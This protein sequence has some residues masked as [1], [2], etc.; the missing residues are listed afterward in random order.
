MTTAIMAKRI[1]PMLATDNHGADHSLLSERAGIHADLTEFE[2][3]HLSSVMVK[4]FVF[5]RQ[6]M[7][8]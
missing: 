5:R 7:K 6:L 4:P 2:L 3:F 8:K 1:S